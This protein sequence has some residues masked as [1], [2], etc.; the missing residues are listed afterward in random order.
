MKIIEGYK[1]KVNSISTQI[2]CFVSIYIASYLL[3]FASIGVDFTDEG[4]YLLEA[5]G[6]NTNAVWGVPY[7]KVLR[8]LFLLSGY[9]IGLYRALSFSILVFLHILIHKE[10]LQLNYNKTYYSQNHWGLF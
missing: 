9:N 10:V 5:G 8:P 2:L 6:L 3:L 7:G 1:H 4:L